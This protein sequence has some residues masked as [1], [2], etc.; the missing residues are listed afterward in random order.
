MPPAVS[1]WLSSCSE[2]ILRTDKSVN[3][4]LTSQPAT[5]IALQD[6]HQLDCSQST[7]IFQLYLP[8]QPARMSLLRALFRRRS[9]KD[10]LAASFSGGREGQK[11]STRWIRP[12]SNCKAPAKVLHQH[13]TKKP[14]E[15]DL[16]KNRSEILS[17]SSSTRPVS[18]PIV[19][20][21]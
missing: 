14:Q 19:S 5:A 17:S 11:P 4:P 7:L 12:Y 20:R 3:H 16:S 21:L 9:P 13:P 2:H 18:K 1:A 6:Q 10:Q 8:G 15:G